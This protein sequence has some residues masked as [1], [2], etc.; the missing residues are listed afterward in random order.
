MFYTILM[1]CQLAFATDMRG[2]W[3]GD[4]NTQLIIPFMRD[5]KMFVL[6]STAEGETQALYGEWNWLEEQLEIKRPSST[7]TIEQGHKEEYL[8][9]TTAKGAVNYQKKTGVSMHPSDGIWYSEQSGEYAPVILGNSFYII[10]M[11]TAQNI[12]LYP[13]KWK[14]NEEGKILTFKAKKKCEVEFVSNQPEKAFVVCGGKPDNWKR[15]YQP[16]PFAEI[17]LTGKWKHSS[18]LTASIT[19]DGTKF[20][21][22]FLE[23]AS[24]ITTYNPSWIAGSAG[25]KFILERKGLPKISGQYDTHNPDELLLIIQG[26]NYIFYKDDIPQVDLSGPS[27]TPS[28]NT[29]AS[30]DGENSS[31]NSGENSGE[32]TEGTD[33]PTN[34]NDTPSEDN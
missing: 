30:E 18:G 31:E 7:W 28:A 22:V 3:K 1:L 33:A 12:M 29:N 23:S 26:E 13:A 20:Q 19:M 6:F 16:Q 34:E 8:L 27:Y 2:L 4:D 32:Q 17:K 10:H 9:L 5:G 11:P 21:E 24:A 25:T 14:K 15:T